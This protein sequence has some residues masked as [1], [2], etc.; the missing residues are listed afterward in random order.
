MRRQFVM[1]GLLLMVLLPALAL[2][3][4]I[5]SLAGTVS[6]Q[7]GAVVSDVTVKLQDTKTGTRYETKTNSAGGYTFARVQPGPGYKLEISKE[8]F[9]SISISDIYVAVGTTHTQNA[10]LRVGKI[11]ESVEVS[12]VEQAVT[13][14]TTD[15]TIGN[16]FDMRNVHELPIQIRDSPAALLVLQPGVTSDNL[17]ADDPN[18]SR[19]GAVTGSRTD[20]GNITLDG[21]DVNDFATGQAFSTVGNAP[22][23]SIQEFRAETA[24]PLA[25][26]GRG[27][28]AQI[29]LVT[30][31]GS[32]D[33]HGSLFEYHRNTIT[34][35]NDFFNKEAGIE[36]P[37]L[38]RNQFGGSIGG[39][40]LKDKLFFFFT[41]QGRRDAKEDSVTTIVPLD[42]FRAGS[43][44]YINDSAGCDESSRINT[45]PNCISFVNPGGVAAFDPQ[46]VGDNA[47]LLSFINGRY[48]QANDLT[49]G[50]G[51]NTGGFRFN[52]PANR[53][54]NDYVAR[55]DYNLTSKMKLFG[56]V[57]ILRDEYGDDRNFAAP[58]RFPGDPITHE[59]LDHSY[60]YV[61][62]HTWA[63]S[64]SKVNQFF[65]GQT[66]SDLNFPTPFNPVGTT[67]YAAFGPLANPYD[68]QETQHRVVPI[69]IFRD[70]FSYVKGKHNFQIGGTFK[71]IRTRS[72]QVN[73]FNFVTM[74]LGGN[75]QNLDDSLRPSDILQDP[76]AVSIGLYDSAFAFALGRFGAIASN[77][78]NSRDLAA[79]PQG[80]GHTRNYR[81]Y[82]SEAYFQDSWRMRSDLTMT[83]GLRY[84]F[85]SVP[86]E[87][88]GLQANPS[89]N[90]ADFYGPRA[91]QGP[92]GS[93]ADLPLLN[94]T[95]GGRA[96]DATGLYKPD[97]KDFA[98]RLAFAYN[99]G[100]D[101]G[102]FGH[103]LGNHKTVV[104]AGA[105][106]V[107]DHP[108]T[109]A[110]NFVQDQATYIFQS[111]SSTIFGS[112][113]PNATA[114]DSLRTD[115]RFTDLGTIPAITPA[116]TITVPF[117]PFV[118]GGVPVGA[119]EGQANYAIDSGLKTPYS[120]TYTLGFQ[121]DLPANFMFEA[122]YFGRLGR[123][124][125]AQ[126]DAGQIVNFKDPVSGHSLVGDYFDLSQQLRNGTDPSAVVAEPFFEGQFPGLTSII[127]E[128]LTGLT[129]R[130]D[131]ADTLQ[132]LDS[133]GLVAPGIGFHPQFGSNV[134]I[135]NKSYSSYNGLLASLHKR[136][137]HGLQF[138]LNYTFSHSID[139][140]SAPASNIFGSGNFA[141]GVICDITNLR[142][143]RGNSDFDLT[144][145]ITGNFIYE[146]PFGRGKEFGSGSSGV[147]NQIIGG[148]QVAGT[149]NWH[150]GFAFTT[151][152]NAFPV[153]FVNNAPAIFDG[154]T[155]AIRTNVHSDPSTGVQ[156]FADPD[157]ARGA[158]RG[159]LGLEGGT[160]NNL[161]GPS[162]TNFDIGVAKHFSLT[163]KVSMEFRA[164][165]FNAF[166][167]VNFGLPGVSSGSAN[168]GTA[169]ISDPSTFGIITTAATPREV[170]FAL[171]LDF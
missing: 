8:G 24:N 23:D 107:F 86:Y 74:G 143:C 112:S 10:E 138:D 162:F 42:N 2:A 155:S 115:P 41:Y 57:S 142:A 156:L 52:A 30:K 124:L 99:P 39:P 118:D 15:A 132:V 87:T 116:P 159:P 147:V 151:V 18:S 102:F 82:E 157:A 129:A 106:V 29:Q 55:V 98:P 166:N 76:N 158:F 58:V 83:Y 92:Q 56:R 62:G 84:Q 150:T 139:N 100:A 110:L 66:R 169:D 81:Y 26:S 61:F 167:H 123:R 133:F 128:N 127:A 31:S 37:K 51:V 53:T 25:A 71:P 73:D 34:E 9:E 70:D 136:L 93:L 65:Y 40:I 153:S 44:G 121:R 88:N 5:G 131:L 104:R 96:N 134:Y 120:I 28:G 80:S 163:E 11:S 89:L 4:E 97:W 49:G 17:T 67:Y 50:D 75:L 152:S 68:Q 60:A 32:N 164:D 43:V 45:Q 108:A 165:A 149:F 48:P 161:R 27:S 130:G 170:Q 36:R 109:N 114:A 154:D 38:L 46:G 13:L 3:Q 35:A 14:D 113:D 54:A 103:L 160:R 22:V 33:W 63:I 69:P 47:A 140:T 85:Y 137:S 135:T 95:L 101:N 148:W 90:L 91:L 141:G 117:Q 171:R 19:D 105:G 78:N 144:H 145:V 77:F 126:A 111:A 59:V 94:Y 64:N 168:G 146:L 72:N 122:A 125:L 21:L 79:L 20:Q 119:A 7:S 12:G 16:N 6:D 1:F